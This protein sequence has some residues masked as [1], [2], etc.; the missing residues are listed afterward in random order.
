MSSS[1]RAL[2]LLRL[3]T[4]YRSLREIAERHGLA[5]TGTTHKTATEPESADWAKAYE[6]LADDPAECDVEPFLEAQVEAMT[7]G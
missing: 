3:D 4:L 6:L 1:I 2:K 5:P 7:G